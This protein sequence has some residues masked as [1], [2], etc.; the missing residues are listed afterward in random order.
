MFTVDPDEPATYEAF[1]RFTDNWEPDATLQATHRSHEMVFPP[2][3]ISRG[4][5]RLPTGSLL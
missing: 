5:I 3:F 1:G 4:S 2:F